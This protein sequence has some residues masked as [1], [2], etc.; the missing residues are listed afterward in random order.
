MILILSIDI[1]YNSWPFEFVVAPSRSHR[2]FIGSRQGGGAANDKFGVSSRINLRLSL[3]HM[4][5][6]GPRFDR[7][8][9]IGNI[10][11]MAP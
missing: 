8:M 6:T 7:Y 5:E 9:G 10:L 3:L 4:Q 1:I 2:I 11:S